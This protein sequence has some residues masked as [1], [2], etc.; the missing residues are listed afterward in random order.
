MLKCWQD[1]PG[2]KQFVKEKLNSF[3]IEGWGGYVL[4]EKLKLIKF[5]L[6]DWHESHTKNIPG[7][8]DALQFRLSELDDKGEEDGLSEEE[9][10][11]MRDISHDLHSLSRLHT[12]IN[13]Q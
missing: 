7:R 1:I 13:W 4:R 10:T 12:S 5:A 2:Y 8:I 9:V 11:E 3:Q 6:K